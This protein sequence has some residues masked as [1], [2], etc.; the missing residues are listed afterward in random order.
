MSLQITC[1][2]SMICELKR[3]LKPLSTVNPPVVIKGSSIS[4]TLSTVI[5]YKWLFSSVNSHMDF[6]VSFSIETFSTLLAGEW[7]FSSVNPHVV[8]K[9]SF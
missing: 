6:Q 3:H 4:E 1:D 9:V 2:V 5:T 7:V 8:N